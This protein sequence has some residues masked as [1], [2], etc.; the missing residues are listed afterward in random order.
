MNYLYNGIELPALPDYDSTTYPYAILQEAYG[1]YRFTVCASPI[2]VNTNGYIAVPTGASG[3]NWELSSGASSWVNGLYGASPLAG[4]PIFWAN[5]NVLNADGTLYLAASE[6]VPVAVT[7]YDPASMLMGWM[8]GRRIAGLRGEKKQVSATGVYDDEFPIQW[9]SLAVA[10]NVKVD[11]GSDSQVLLK[12]SNLAPTADELQSCEY[13]MVLGEDTYTGSCTG[14]ESADDITVAVYNDIG[15]FVLASVSAPMEFDGLVFP[16]SGLYWATV[17]GDIS[18]DVT[19]TLPSVVTYN[20]VELPDIETVWTD[21]ETYPYAFIVELVT[22]SGSYAFIMS[23][24]PVYQAGT[25]VRLV[26]GPGDS[27]CYEVN[28][29]AWSLLWTVSGG[30]AGSGLVDNSIVI[31]TNTDI[32]DASGAL[33]LAASDPVY[34]S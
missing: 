3:A 13:T 20:G 31:W 17:I 27:E 34:E 11:L 26:T 24:T 7:T 15:G 22:H 19:I 5:Y 4:F 1:N 29:N 8:V 10:D 21:K 16:E 28:G 25:T 2:Y 23:A 30:A 9:N 32:N 18:F 14:I 6:P 33:F 12:V